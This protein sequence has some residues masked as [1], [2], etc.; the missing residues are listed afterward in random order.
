MNEKMY[1][2]SCGLSAVPG[3]CTDIYISLVCFAR[4]TRVSTSAVISVTGPADND[5]LAR[6]QPGYLV[7]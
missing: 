3:S 2:F 1:T 6:E 7:V 5:C 4:I